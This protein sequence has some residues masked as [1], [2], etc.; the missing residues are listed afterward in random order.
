M[1]VLFVSHAYVVG[2][3]Q[4]KLNA[5]AQ[6]KKVKVG[7]LTP[8]NWKAREWDSFLPVEKPYPDIQVYSAPVSFTGRGGAC[9][10]N[11][12][13]VWQVIQDFKPDLI[14]VEQE[15]F[16]ICAFELAVFSRIINKPLV[17]F[18]WENMERQLSFFRSRIRRFVLNTASLIITGNHDGAN[19]VRGWGYEGLLEIMPQMGVDTTLFAPQTERKSSKQLQIGF[20]GRLVTEKGIDTLLRAIA[21]LRH[22]GLN[23]QGIICGFGSE[24]ANL[25]QQAVELNIT[26][27]IVWRGSVPHAL[28]PAELSQF[29]VLVLPSRTIDNWKEQFGHVLIEAMAMEIPVVGSTCG[30]IPDVIGRSDLVFEEEDSDALAAILE[31]IALQPA[32]RQEIA[33]YCLNRV[34]ENYSHEK[35]AERLIGLWQNIEQRSNFIMTELNQ[36]QQSQSGERECA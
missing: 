26:D 10:Y 31:K 19:L 28:A 35:I 23:C 20:L 14:Q 24:E 18:G 5:I 30:E 29:D 25:R 15:V 1:R 13:R 11:P 6:T 16:S 7:L 36:N 4:D 3:N 12:L 8:S 21:K 22:R 17:V 34:K 33:T 27:N 32:W 9:F 2:V